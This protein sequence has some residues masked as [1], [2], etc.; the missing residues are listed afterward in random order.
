MA[1]SNKQTIK[2]K[3][4]IKDVKK[5]SNNYA[6]IISKRTMSNYTDL[7]W[8]NNGLGDRW[9]NKLFN[10]TSIYKNKIKTYSD[11][12]EIP[13]L[14]LIKTFQLTIREK[15]IIGI[16]PHSL[17]I[18]NCGRPISVVIKRHIRKQSCVAC[19]SNSDIICDHKNDLYNNPKVLNIRTQTLEDFQS[20]CNSCN[21]RK[22]QACKKEKELNK[23][24]SIKNIPGY[25]VYKYDFP[26]EKIPYDIT[27][28]NIKLNTYWYD[29]IQFIGKIET[30][31]K[32]KQ[33][34]SNIKKIKFSNFN[35]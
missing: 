33:V 17:K 1:I 19:G 5:L 7:I 28:P 18:D 20:L 12:D 22:R 10:Y 3:Q 13:D 16:L 27:N 29:P 34:L 6:T 9:S 35:L 15:G 32:Y 24:Y 11:N 2:A 26:W 4:T 23:L 25:Q 14:N 21:L 31:S 30:Y 8:W